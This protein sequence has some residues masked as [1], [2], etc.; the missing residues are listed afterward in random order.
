MS[1]LIRSFNEDFAA[2]V[3]KQPEAPAFM[4]GKGSED[5]VI[6][7]SDLA[8]LV[9]RAI[10]LIQKEGL[11]EG[12]T[13]LSLMPNA[14]E[15][16][17]LFFASIKGGFNFAPL[18]CTASKRELERWVLLTRPK[19]CFTTD[20]INNDK[21][22]LAKAKL[23][24]IIVATNTQFTWLPDAAEYTENKKQSLVYLSTSGT[25]GDPKA[26]VID[27]DVLWS[28][29]MAFVEFH[30]LSGS[31]ARFWNYLP[32]SYLGGLFNLAIIPLCTG[33]SAVIDEPFSGK[34]FL[35]FWQFVDRFD[36]DTLWLVPTIM[37]GLI[38]LA[39]RIK[40]EIALAYKDKIN[41]CF[42]G[43]APIDLST[44][45]KFTE[46]FGI[47]PLENF[48][49]SETTF[50]TSETADKI[51]SRTEKSV[52][53]LLPYVD[54][55]FNPVHDEEETEHKEI[56]VKTPFLF[57]GYLQEGGDIISPVDSDG[58]M[59]T[60]DL[61]YDDKGTLFVSGRSRDIIKKGG[62]FVPLREVEI[63]SGQYNGVL[64]AIAVKTGHPFYGESYIL[65]LKTT[66]KDEIEQSFGG[67]LHENLV[68]YKWPEKI[69]YV[70]DFPR[71]ASGKVRKHLLLEAEGA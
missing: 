33:G 23:K 44:K 70:D 9:D 10:A 53:E 6:S 49:L 21:E 5:N 16:L 36:I 55:K 47:I 27:A 38:Q 15:T 57:K 31:K 28:S 43:T 19:I 62:Y 37:K 45:Q 32:M 30:G 24:T 66:N 41:T 2:I 60:G 61:G 51:N 35:Q 39:S 54:I 68:Q 65:F 40:P 71:T 22:A 1:S 69:I 25:T 20:L 42:L 14:I 17:V 56:Y 18:P 59:P 4:D 58:Y 63:L 13:I 50:I 3:A 29:G 8:K 7:Y 11:K 64:E 52:G 46:L 48:A 12:D 67:W 26:I 34:T